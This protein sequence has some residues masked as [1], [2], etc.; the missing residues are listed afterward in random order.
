MTIDEI[1]VVE[2]RDDTRAVKD[3]VD[4]ATIETHGFGISR[5]TWKRL[6]SAYEKKGLIILTDPDHAGDGIR[7]RLKEKF[8]EAKEAF[9][10]R[11]RALK[12]GDVGVENADKEAI[13]KALEKALGRKIPPA[14]E[15]L[16]GPNGGSSREGIT[17]SDLVMLGLSGSPESR[18]LRE[19]AGDILGIGYGNAKAFLKR[20]ND[21][22][23]KKGDL[24][25]AV[26]TANDK[27]HKG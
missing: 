16:K 1:I 25:E 19:E 22:G 12:A 17:E 2:G 27:I 14:C 23:I 9:V 21:Y 3:A 8:P 18:V 5:D 4:C 10:K 26:R 13:V 20:L 6:E 15:G 7:K 11:S 24:D